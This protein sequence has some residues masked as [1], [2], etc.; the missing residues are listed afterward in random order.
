MQELHNNID[1]VIAAQPQTLTTTGSPTQVTSG[2]IDLQG[3]EAA[4]IVG[5]LG[6][7]D[8]L[9]GSPVGTAKVELMLEHST[10]GTTFEA[11]ALTDVVG[12]SSVTSGVVASTTTDGAASRTPEL[13]CGYR[14]T[15]RYIKCHLVGTALANGGQVAIL[16]AKGRERHKGGDTA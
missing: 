4:E 8:E 12:P 14:M 15:R 13:T 11:V 16:V 1:W 9:G 7:I 2:A 6:D 10:D 3:Y 5:I